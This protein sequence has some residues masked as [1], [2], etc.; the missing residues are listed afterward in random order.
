MK[1]TSLKIILVLILVLCTSVITFAAPRQD[2]GLL[3]P[4]GRKE[5]AFDAYAASPFTLRRVIIYDNIEI[6][7]VMSDSRVVLYSG[8]EVNESTVI[9]SSNEG[10]INWNVPV[11][12]YYTL[13]WT[14][15]WGGGWYSY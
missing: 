8:P 11:S 13:T 9:T 7:S 10:Y 4:T 3:V 15:T 2:L 5:R 14:D 6:M 1:K 12:D